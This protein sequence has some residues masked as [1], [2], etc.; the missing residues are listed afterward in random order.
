MTEPI[1]SLSGLKK[2][3][4]PHEGILPRAL[5]AR[6]KPILAVDGV[7]LELRRGETLG[8]VGESGC[9]KSTL[10]RT[11]LLL[12]RPTAGEVVFDRANLT[13]LAPQKLRAVRR[14]M[15][16]VFQDPAA[17]L[18]PRKSVRSILQ[19]PIRMSGAWD[20]RSGAGELMRLVGL[21]QDDLSRYPHQF[22][23][24][25]K[26]RIGIARALASRPDVMIADEPVASLDVSVQAQILRLLLDLQQEFG[27]SYMFI[28]HDLDVVRKVSD[29]V[30]VMY[31]GKV[32]ELGS[33]SDVVGSPLHPYTQAL[34]SAIPTLPSASPA[35]PASA[36]PL[37]SAARSNGGRI[38]L[39]GE[40]PDPSDPPTGCRFH[41]RCFMDKI[42]ECETVEPELL[43]VS[44]GRWAACHLV[45]SG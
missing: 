34:I 26:Q 20:A 43:E 16:M 19:A 21:S 7:D 32:V 9:G 22:S 39:A 1:L 12:E 42:P 5:G 36:A 44:P 41:P 6:A 10:G 11:A 8:L 37:R 3:Y 33:A 31:L 27:L 4:A 28:S 23:G 30:A 15:Q 35:D 14:R 17:S 24:G 38:V 40:V 25:Q 45:S 13:D 18:N 29:R 2:H